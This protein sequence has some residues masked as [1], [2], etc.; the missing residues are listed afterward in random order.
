MISVLPNLLGAAP[1]SKDAFD[2]F[3]ALAKHGGYHQQVT[4]VTQIAPSLPLPL[5]IQLNTLGSGGYN[6]PRVEEVTVIHE[7]N[8][9]L[10]KAPVLI[11]FKGTPKEAARRG[12]ILFYHGFTAAKEVNR[13]EFQRLAHNGYLAVGVDNCGHGARRLADFEARFADQSQWEHEF[14]KLT[15]QTAAEVP[16]LLDLLTQRKWLYP[17]KAGIAGISMG[18]IIAYEAVTLDSRL[19]ACATIVATPKWVVPDAYD[20]FYPTAVLSQTAGKDEVINV[21]EAI[22]FHKALAPH[23]AEAPERHLHIDYPESGHMMRGE[24]FHEAFRQLIGWFDRYLQG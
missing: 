6:D 8:E 5:I 10:G 23:Y 4:D 9:M 2:F 15:G 11:C 19:A 3:R 7:H 17:G 22:D 24:D 13:A 12:T 18:G 21:A 20:R 14:L 1:Y 16:G